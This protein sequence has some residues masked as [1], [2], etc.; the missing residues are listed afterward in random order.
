MCARAT[1]RACVG[2]PAHVYVLVVFLF[3]FLNTC[4]CARV[5][6]C[7]CLCARVHACAHTDGLARVQMLCARMH[8][9]AYLCKRT[10]CATWCARTCILYG[11]H[12]CVRV[13]PS[14]SECVSAC[15]CVVHARSFASAYTCVCARARS[16]CL[17]MGIPACA[18]AC[19]CPSFLWYAHV[20]VC[21]YM[22]ACL[23]LFRARMHERLFASLQTQMVAKDA[24]A[25][26]RICLRA[27][28]IARG[29]WPWLCARIFRLAH[30]RVDP[31]VC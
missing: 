29:A 31:C 7:V 15:T 23:R 22:R 18:H 17:R 9:G 13:L 19:F 12:V 10:P 26:A 28:A 14:W 25:Y 27:R 4:L 11:T 1:W 30:T 6:A 16:G 21:V 8:V 5:Y 20:C 3:S 2:V 24:T